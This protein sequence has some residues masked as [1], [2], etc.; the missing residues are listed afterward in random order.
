MLYINLINHD[1]KYEVS[2]LIKLFTNNFEFCTEKNFARVLENRLLTHNDTIISTSRYYTNYEMVFEE[3]QS[4]N[5]L[6]K[7]KVKCLIVS[8]RLFKIMICSKIGVY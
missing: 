7:V 3:K 4:I 8:N 5:A 6:R 1:L 2:E